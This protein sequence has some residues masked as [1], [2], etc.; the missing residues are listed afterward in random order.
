MA[1]NDPD[2]VLY[3]QVQLSGLSSRRAARAAEIAA[4]AS[5]SAG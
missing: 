1:S 5:R 2:T 3:R 4:C